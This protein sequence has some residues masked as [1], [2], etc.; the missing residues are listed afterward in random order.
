MRRWE[1]EREDDYGYDMTV[2]TA[3]VLPTG[4]LI[5]A[6][7]QTMEE[8]DSRRVMGGPLNISRLQVFRV[9]NISIDSSRLG[10]S[11]GS[12]GQLRTNEPL[13]EA[14]KAHAHSIGQQLFADREIP[15]N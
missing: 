7:R 13:R 9:W 5:I 3:V 11:L 12:S 1:I 6:R 2:I 8:L 10:S 15:R 4:W 14:H